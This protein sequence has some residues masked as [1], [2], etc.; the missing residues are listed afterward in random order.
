MSSWG[1][2]FSLEIPANAKHPKEAF[3]FISWMATQGV[4][5]WAKEQ[6][7]IPGNIAAVNAVA[8]TNPLFKQVFSRPRPALHDPDL[9]LRTFSF[10]SGH[11]MGATA[12]YGA[13]AI[14]VARR[15]R[16][17]VWAPVAVAAA[18]VLVLLIGASRVY[19]GA[20]YPSDVVA[21]FLLGLLWL[22]VC[23]LA[24]TIYDRRHAL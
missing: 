2:G 7:D 6:N 17:T 9:T 4:Q 19:L 22:L 1:G 23:V 20:H 3:Q 10:P 12:V 16:G 24:L 5:T 18:V 21:G 8:A 13:L 11:A 14:V 15:L